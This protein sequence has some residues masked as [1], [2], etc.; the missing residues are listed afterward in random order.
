M[1][2]NFDHRWSPRQLVRFGVSHHPM[3]APGRGWSY[4]NTN[5]VVAQLIIE[6]ATG[7]TLGAELKRRIFAPLRLRHTSYGTALGCA[8]RVRARLH[9]ARETPADRRDQ[10]Q[11]HPRP[12]IRRDRLDRARGRRLLPRAAL[13]GAAS[14]EAAA[15]DETTVSQKTGKD[16]AAGAGYG[17]GIARTN[18]ACGGWGH[19][20]ELPGYDVSTR[21]QRGR[22]SPGRPDDQ[23]GRDHAP[24][25]ALPR[26]FRLLERAFCARS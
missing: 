1:A 10:P 6:R 4:S 18:N 26:Y 5:Y 14:P 7:N 21:V 8:D 19:S 15:G 3:F 17:L 22:P 16:A 23:P 24:K 11:P 12:R 9:A 13:R 2:G 25:P 20:G